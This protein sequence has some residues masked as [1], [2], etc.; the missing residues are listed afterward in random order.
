MIDLFY[1]KAMA[2]KLNIKSIIEIIKVEKVLFE[3]NI[4]N[5]IDKYEEIIQLE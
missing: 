3:M 5:K 2:K 4:L 1:I